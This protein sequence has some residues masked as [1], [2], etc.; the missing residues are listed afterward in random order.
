[1]ADRGRRGRELLEEPLDRS[2]Q[3]AAVEREA[4]GNACD[5]APIRRLRD[6]QQLRAA[7]I[8]AEE[9]A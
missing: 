5:D 8:E 1:M 9:Q 6:H 7:E 2:L 3:R 4:G